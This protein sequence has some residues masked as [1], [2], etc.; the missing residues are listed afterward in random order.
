VW[1]IEIPNWC[2][3][4]KNKG[5]GRHWSRDAKLTREVVEYLT[6]YN[7]RAGVPKVRPDYRPVRSVALI[8]RKNG[9]LPDPDNLLK[10]FLDGLKGA[11]MIVDDS[12]KWC[13][14]KRPIVMNPSKIDPRRFTLVVIEDVPTAAEV[15]EIEAWFS[16][17]KRESD[18]ARGKK[19]QPPTRRATAKAFA[20][21]F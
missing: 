2:P 11:G 3:P 21:E 13:H 1:T 20:F 16:E 5:R 9:S 15:A 18:A 10:H 12:E 7:A 4:S 19:P 6:A 17:R 14:W 8:V